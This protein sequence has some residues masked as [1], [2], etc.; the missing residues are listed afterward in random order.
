MVSRTNPGGEIISYS[1]NPQ[2]EVNQVNGVVK[3][4]DYNAQGKITKKEYENSVNTEYTY[5]ADDFRLNRILTANFQDMNYTYD[6]VGNIKTIKNNI[7]NTTQNFGYDNLSRL[8]TAQ[9]SGKYDFAYNYN[10]IGNLMKFTNSGKA[11]DYSYGQNAGVHA[12]TSSTE[13]I[14]PTPSPTPTPISTPTPTPTPTPTLVPT[15]TPTPTPG[16]KTNIAPNG[17]GYWWSKNTSATA[18]TN[19]VAAAG[20]N[21]LNMTQD[22]VV[23]GGFGDFLNSWEA[24]GVIWATT[25][26]NVN[27]AEYTNGSY[28]TARNGVFTANFRLQLSSDGTTWTN[29]SWTCTPSY[30]YDSSSAA[31]KTYT[32]SGSA[33][34]VKGVRIT[35]QVATFLSN[36]WYVNVAELKA[37]TTGGSSPTSTPTPTPSPKPTSTP[38]PTPTPTKTVTPTLTPTPTR[39]P[40]P[41]PTPTSSLPSPTPTPTPT[42][43][44][45]PTPTRS[46]TPTPTSGVSKPD[47][48]VTRIVLS[49]PNPRVNVFF[50]VNVYIKNQ[51]TVSTPFPSSVKVGIYYDLTLPPTT[52]TPYKS[53]ATYIST[54]SPGEEVIVT[55]T[56]ERFTTTGS[57]SIWALADQSGNITESNEGNNAFGPL[58]V[59]ISP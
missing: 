26:N 31:G 38:T 6:N 20:I 44:P 39:A 2:G 24:A 57:H 22:V 4:I 30:P 46:V 55:K 12:L 52:T 48:I 9:E 19:R 59:T 7:L 45:T 25:Q 53:S 36:S 33:A 51:G 13:E 56:F 27:S 47:L 21:D 14:N 50:D 42:S 54:I 34:S 29:S 11:I 58:N 3:N 18:N 17:I 35:G 49:V 43:K 15:Q 37:F 32:C 1:F 23:N 40:T 5:S 8:I 16:G 41:T 28:T 10:A